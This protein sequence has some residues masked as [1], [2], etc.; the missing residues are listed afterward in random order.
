MAY[1]N[2][3]NWFWIDGELFLAQA[4]FTRQRAQ[5]RKRLGLPL[6]RK[7]ATKIELGWRMME[8]V[9]L[10]GLPFEMVCCDTLYGR[11][12]W[13]RRK[14][15]SAGLIY[16]AAVPVDTRVYVAQ[17][18]VGVPAHKKGRRATKPRVLRAEKPLEVRPLAT[19]PAT[20]WTRIKVRS[21]ERGY[22]NDE[23]S[24]RRIWTTYNGEQGFLIKRNLQTRMHTVIFYSF[25]T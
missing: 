23:F 13:L 14:M 2:D 11:S 12:H 24:A 22:L 10:E 16:Y 18:V 4:W 7:F 15:S 3:G 21:T 25:A 1:A 9:S 20:V 6:E 5:E 19:L 8:R 17:P